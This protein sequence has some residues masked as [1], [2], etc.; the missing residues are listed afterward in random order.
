MAENSS[1]SRAISRK[2]QPLALFLLRFGALGAREKSLLGCACKI[3]GSGLHYDD[4]KI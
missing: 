2:N 1:I 4:K 3:R